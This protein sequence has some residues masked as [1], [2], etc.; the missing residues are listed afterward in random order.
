M[1]RYSVTKRIPLSII[2]KL[3]RDFIVIRLQE[4]EKELERKI[5]EVLRRQST[6]SADDPWTA[7]AALGPGRKGSQVVYQLYYAESLH[8]NLCKIT[9]NSSFDS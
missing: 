5:S 8:V 7:E 6:V 1:A 4:E 2:V 3:L 9:G